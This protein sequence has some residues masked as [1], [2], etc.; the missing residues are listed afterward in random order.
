[1]DDTG[2]PSPANAVEAYNNL[3]YQQHDAVGEVAGATIGPVNGTERHRTATGR[4]RNVNELLFGSPSWVSPLGYIIFMPLFRNSI[5]RRM[6]ESP[7]LIPLLKS[8][9]K[10]FVLVHVSTVWRKRAG[11]TTKNV[12]M[13]RRI[14]WLLVTRRRARANT[15]HT[16]SHITA[17]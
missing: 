10:H 14:S 9:V 15:A 4:L 1:M 7:F 5:P 16:R 11:E 3:H 6:A 12:E 2:Q 13:T 8:I 17:R